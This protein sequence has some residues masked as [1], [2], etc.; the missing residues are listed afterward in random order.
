MMSDT[1]PDFFSLLILYSILVDTLTCSVLTH[2]Y[3]IVCNDSG[4]EAL[5]RDS[6]QRKPL[7]ASDH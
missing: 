1:L 5:R 7:N 6:E 4:D 3:Y 2:C